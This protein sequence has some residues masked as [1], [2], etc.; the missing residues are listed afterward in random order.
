MEG[1]LS[2]MIVSW[3]WQCVFGPRDEVLIPYRLEG[4]VLQL[5]TTKVRREVDLS[6]FTE[7]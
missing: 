3:G 4:S 6:L 1:T 5:K 2:L 7:I